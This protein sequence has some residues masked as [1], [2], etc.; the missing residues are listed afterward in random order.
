MVGAASE[1]GVTCGSV[2]RPGSLVRFPRAY[3]DNR[4]AIVGGF[5]GLRRCRVFFSGAG[6]AVDYE[7]ETLDGML[8]RGAMVVDVY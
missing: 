2:Y 1:P 5:C 7:R 4:W 3:R 6:M 8:K